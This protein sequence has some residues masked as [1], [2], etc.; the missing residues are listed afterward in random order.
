[1][2][3]RFLKA[4]KDCAACGSKVGLQV[5]HVQPF[6]LAPLLELAPENLVA[7]C[8]AVGGLECHERIGHGASFKAYNPNVLDDCAELR[9]NPGKLREILARV[10]ANRRRI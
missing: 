10:R 5:H 1:V 7:L 2:R 4:N 3:K 9:A 8:M 6:H